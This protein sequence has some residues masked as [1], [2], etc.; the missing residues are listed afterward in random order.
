M[1]GAA[2]VASDITAALSQVDSLISLLINLM[3]M[4][5][6]FFVLLLTTRDRRCLIENLLEIILIILTYVNKK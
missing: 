3:L 4:K 1:T 5:N 2:I 6:V